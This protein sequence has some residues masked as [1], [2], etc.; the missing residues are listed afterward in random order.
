MH[1]RFVWTEIRG[2]PKNISLIY[3]FT[4]WLQSVFR[5]RF[6]SFHGQFCISIQYK[7]YTIGKE[8][9]NDNSCMILIQSC[10]YF[11][12]LRKCSIFLS[13]SNVKQSWNYYYIHLPPFPSTYVYK[14]SKALKLVTAIKHIYTSLDPERILSYIQYF[15]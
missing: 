7:I 9:S 5:L 2:S 4:V 13:E 11:F 6:M 3:L 8:T 14:S 12:S 15:F 1:A 10:H